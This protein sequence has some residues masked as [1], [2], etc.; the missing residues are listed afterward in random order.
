MLPPAPQEPD[1]ARWRWLQQQ[2]AARGERRLVVVEGEPAPALDWLR[3]ELPTLAMENGVWTGAAGAS[4]DPR[5]TPV[6]PRKARQ[7]LGR[8]LVGVVWDGGHGKPPDGLA[9]LA[10][11]LKAGGLLFWL[12]PPLTRWATFED[13]DYA[14]TGLEGCEH[15]PFAARLSAIL[16]ASPSVIRINPAQGECAVLPRLEHPPQPFAIAETA[17]QHRVV[18]AIVRTGQGRRRRPLVIT[19][20]R[21]RGKSA[22]LGIAAVRLLQ[23]G[24][25]HVVV[26]APS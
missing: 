17:D 10:G 12:M 13:P 14:R 16:A 24:R 11:T 15:H 26:T 1:V 7:W 4:P 3:Q 19:A 6:L 2:L 9:A 5:L 8:E 23:Q 21:G 25:R 22:A 18:E 20:D